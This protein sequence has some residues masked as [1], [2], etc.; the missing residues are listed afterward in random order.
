MTSGVGVNVDVGMGVAVTIITMGV[1]LGAGITDDERGAPA[2]FVGGAGGAAG[3]GGNIPVRN[4]K[5]SP[6]MNTMSATAAMAAI[7]LNGAMLLGLA[8]ASGGGGG[9]YGAGGGAGAVA[10]T[11]GAVS[12]R[13][14]SAAP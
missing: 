8:G 4:K 12:A 6:R 5:P 1:T 10:V 2:T 13:F 11:L 14:I 9:A 7:I 3:L